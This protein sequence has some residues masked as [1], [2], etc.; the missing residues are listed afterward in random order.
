MRLFRFYDFAKY[1]EMV[2]RDLEIRTSIPSSLNDPFEL[3]P[4][5]DPLQFTEETV[6]SLLQRNWI[7]DGFFE[8]EGHQFA[9]RAE[10]EANYFATIHDR[11]V[12]F[13]PGV[14]EN[15]EN[16]EK[17]FDEGFSRYWRLICMSRTRNSI[18][19]WSH[20]AEQHTG[21]VIEFETSEPPF[22]AL[23]Q[24]FIARVAYSDQKPAYMHKQ[25]P[26]EFE[27]EMIRVAAT[28]A[29]DWKYEEEFRVILEAE[30]L[31]VDR[32]FKISRSCIKGVTMGCN[33]TAK[34]KE[35]ILR[36]LDQTGLH[37]VSFQTASRSKSEYALTFD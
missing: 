36:A 12:Q 16:A 37:H 13:L 19:M 24:R 5:I 28:K 25:L 1:G 8:I 4:N 6:E 27:N 18:L 31:R 7:V 29:T 14:R 34:D 10:F 21:L 2:L 23:D 3:K 11:A 17:N 26:H 35:E 32:Y 15:V 33:S 9:N 22:S 20:Y 30:D